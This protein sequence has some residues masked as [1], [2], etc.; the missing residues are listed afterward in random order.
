MK[1]LKTAALYGV[2]MGVYSIASVYI[3]V[4]LF[5]GPFGL[6][7]PLGGLAVPILF[8]WPRWFDR[9]TGGRWGRRLMQRLI[10]VGAAIPAGALASFL[11]VM[12]FPGY[13]AWGE[14]VHRESL[15][16]H[17]RSDAEIEAAVAQHRQV[18]ADFLVDGAMVTGMPGIIASLVTTGAGAVVLRKRPQR[19]GP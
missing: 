7:I 16:A 1:R 9:D 5:P 4:S 12:A 6:L 3:V 10:V 19:S 17:G 11:V 13:I 18:P 15:K 8:L 14:N 2:A